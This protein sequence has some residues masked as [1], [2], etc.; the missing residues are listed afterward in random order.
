MIK[1]LQIA[2]IAFTLFSSLAVQA[3]LTIEITKGVAAA[4]PIAVTPFEHNS[5]LQALDLAQVIQDDL[6]LSGYFNPLPRQALPSSVSYENIPTQAWQS[7]GIENVIQGE[8]N[9]SRPGVYT[10][11]V[12]LKDLFTAHQSRNA[13]NEHVQPKVILSQTFENVSHERLRDLAHHMSDLIFEKLTGIKGAF[14]TR[15][16]YVLVE[17][18]EREQRQYRLEIADMDGFNPQTL[19]R[20]PEPIMSPA[21][22]PDGHQLAFVSFEGSRS[23]IFIADVRNGS[24]KLISSSPGINGAPAWSPDGQRLAIVLSKERSPNIYIVDLASQS[25]EPL[26]EGFN[27]N[28]E[29]NWSPDGKRILFTSNRGGKPQIYEVELYSRQVKRLTYEGNYNARGAYTPDGKSIV[30]IHRNEDGLFRIAKQNLSNNAVTY[31]TYARQDESPSIAPNGAM[32]LY[33]TQVNDRGV[34]GVVS[35]DGRGQLR[36]PAREGYAQEPAWSPFMS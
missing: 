11:N 10:I 15:I 24:R 5:D 31:L 8:I 30:M 1:R 32:V 18:P 13:S 35:M 7:L 17:N 14:S 3:K 21:W 4:I 23:K 6:K 36:L 16:A 25:I 28:T 9:S 27:I 2:L 19:M 33:G 26:T 12:K 34:L 20:S 22:S 29:P